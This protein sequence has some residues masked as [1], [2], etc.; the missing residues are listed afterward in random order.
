MQPG[1]AQEAKNINKKIKVEV[2]EKTFRLIFMQE[3]IFLL[4][5]EHLLEYVFIA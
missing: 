5:N 4:S 3:G 1:V 2:A